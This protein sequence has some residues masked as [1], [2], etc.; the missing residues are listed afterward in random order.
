MT[1]ARTI[2]AAQLLLLFGS[3][4]FAAGAHIIGTLWLPNGRISVGTPGAVMLACVPAGLWLA[5]FQIRELDS[6]RPKQY[7]IATFLLGAFL[8][9][10]IANFVTSQLTPPTLSSSRTLTPFAI[11]QLVRA[12]AVVGIGQE[13]CKYLVVRYGVY[14]SAEFDSA[15]DGILYMTAAALGFASYANYQFLTAHDGN[16]LLSVA[17]I[18]VAVNALGHVAFACVTGFALQQCKFS[19][20]PDLTRVAWLSIGLILAAVANAQFAVVT[21][22]LGAHNIVTQPWKELAYAAGF[23]ALVFVTL[24]SLV[25]RQVQSRGSYHG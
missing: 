7:V 1:R 10:P 18:H 19:G 11:E 9:G 22:W 21:R 16:L 13:F 8:A 5:Y 23:C 3:L 24:T 12:F 20:R 25:F 14:R 4:V 6:A 2:V 17:S 15:V